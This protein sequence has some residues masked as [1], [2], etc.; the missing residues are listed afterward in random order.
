MPQRACT[1]LRTVWARGRTPGT[2][3]VLVGS[4]AS[5]VGAYLFQ[6][7]GTR[8]LGT[9]GYAPIGMLWTI[10]YLVVT[11]PLLS[12]EAYVTR[13]VTLHTDD[14]EGLW[15]GVRT[16]A[17]WTISVAVT[18]TATMWVWRDALFHGSGDSFP[19]IA[20]LIVLCFGAYVMIRGWLAGSSR[21]GQ[22]GIATGI[23]SMGR[24]AIAL[25]IALALPSAGWMAWTLPLGPLLVVAWWW[26]AVGDLR[27]NTGGRCP[28]STEGSPG[29]LAAVTSGIRVHARALAHFHT[30]AHRG[31]ARPRAARQPG[32]FEG[33]PSS[34]GRYLFAT[35][36][37]NACS[38]TL[39]AAGPLVLVPLG[40]SAAETSVFFI[41]ITAA[42]APLVFAIGGVLSRVLPPLTRVARAG[43][44]VRLRRI[45]VLE[46]GAVIV[47]AALGATI[48]FW[49]GPGIVALAF[50]S[51][52]RPDGWFV[53]LTAAGVVSATAALGL[54]QMLIAMGEEGRLI[55]PWAVALTTGALTVIGLGGSPT[56]RVASA[57][58]VGEAV[59]LAGL[60]IAV[61]T[62]QPAPSTEPAG[63]LTAAGAPATLA[64]R[65]G[66]S[67]H[68]AA[69]ASRSPLALLR[70]LAYLPT[71]TRR[72]SRDA[73]RL[74]RQAQ[75]GSFMQKT[76]SLDR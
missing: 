74:A 38:Q 40:A 36:I 44:F 26:L 32:L 53:A 14:S 27:R 2:T 42:R 30:R 35:T 11:I 20:G 76:S 4:L 52:F 39:L 23:E 8:T 51:D 50:G 33:R 56:L 7:I 15:R 66:S 48:G 57:F 60:L 58:V 5:G 65:L 24:V 61:L 19:F 75:S 21:F 17:A 71:V 16:L 72:S 18:L 1:F 54:N 59:A 67:M 6:V 34:P 9:R 25:P 55:A 37:A 12:V 43:N 62:A 73:L 47:L 49:I 29:H 64:L 10:Q 41:T 31:R 63:A 28:E 3:A 13:A 70:N 22:Y 69:P 46:V 45:A 68:S